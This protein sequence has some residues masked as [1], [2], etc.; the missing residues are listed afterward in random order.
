MIPVVV[1]H[2]TEPAPPMAVLLEACSGVVAPNSCTAAA[3]NRRPLAMVTLGP[4]TR[5]DVCVYPTVA[6]PAAA[7]PGVWSVDAVHCR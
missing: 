5:V 2:E 7:A 4:S 6:E 3:P 1:L